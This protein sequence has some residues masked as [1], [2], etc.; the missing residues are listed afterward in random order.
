VARSMK[1]VVVPQA[2]GP[3]VLSLRTVPRPTPG[4]GEILV[5]VCASGVNR[6]DLLQR[7]GGY[8][9]P[10]G[11]PSDIPGLEYS[12]TVRST[13][14]GVTRWLVGD[15]VMGIV[16]GGGYAEYVVTHEDT[17][18]PV[19]VELGA[20]EAGAVPEVFMTAFDAVFLQA[21]LVEGETLLVHAVGSGVGTAAL[22]MGRASGGR[23]VGTSRTPAKLD[24][25]RA[26]GLEHAVPAG[27]DWPERVLELT[28]GLGVDVILDLVGGSYLAGNQ[29][30]LA[31]GGRHIVVGVPSGS[32]SEIDLRLLMRK[33]GSIRGT[34]LRSRGVEEKAALARAFEEVVV[35]RLAAGSVRPVVDRV[36]GPADAGEAHRRMEANV[37]FGK[38]LLSWEGTN[39]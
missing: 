26:L 31:S 13:G 1:A 23:V 36:Y 25:A 28:D 39:N 14:E 18:V 32:H 15:P 17:A 3:E 21:A 35:P 12:G 19:P 10:P 33:R 38:I 8:P 22:Q 2:G 34:V 9:A 27:D 37:N 7:R 29:R 30:V 4:P 6:A 11:A 5:R 16:A 20:V 24:R